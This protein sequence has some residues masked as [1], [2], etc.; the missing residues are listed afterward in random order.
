MKQD[1]GNASLGVR[2]EILGVNAAGLEVGNPIITDGRDLPWLQDTVTDQVWTT[3]GVTYRD[4]WVL[5]RNNRL[6]GIFN[7]TTHNLALPANY[8]MLMDLFQ[9]AASR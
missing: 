1:L 7:V 3:W 4:V 2:L 5:D 6:V 8:Q 9:Q